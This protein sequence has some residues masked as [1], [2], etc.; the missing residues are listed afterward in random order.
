MAKH[1]ELHAEK[2]DVLGK[3]VRRLRRDGILP[4]T[5]YGYQVQPQ[6]IQ[7]DARALRDVIKTSGRTQLVDL[8][9]GSERARPVFIRQTTVDAK[10]NAI[11]HVEFYQANL[12]QKLTTSI[13]VQF[14]GESQAVK[15]GGI[16]LP[17]LDHIDVESLPDDVP[18]AVEADISAIQEINGSMHVGDLQVPDGVSILTSPEEVVAKVNPPVAAEVVEEALAPEAL[19]EELG[20]EEEQPDA[21]PEA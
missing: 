4:A 16:F 6:A 14:V 7:I 3:K 21:V 19:P 12:S 17:L 18:A 5:V 2:R 10:R 11:L 1:A 8:K 13:P 9:I 15:D 20:G